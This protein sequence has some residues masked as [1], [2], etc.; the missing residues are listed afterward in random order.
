MSVVVIGQ[1]GGPMVTNTVSMYQLI[2]YALLVVGLILATR[3][4]VLI[5][6]PT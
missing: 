4:M 1:D 3:V 6:R 5:Y 2:G